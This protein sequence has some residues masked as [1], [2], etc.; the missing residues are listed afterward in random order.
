MILDNGLLIASLFSACN[1][2]AFASASPVP[3]VVPSTL[4]VAAVIY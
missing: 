3:I 1:A 2:E 4:S